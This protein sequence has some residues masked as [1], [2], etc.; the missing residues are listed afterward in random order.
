LPML[1]PR[2]EFDFIRLTKMSRDP[3]KVEQNSSTSS[4][5]PF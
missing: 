2:L 4:V 5:S 3:L 1:R